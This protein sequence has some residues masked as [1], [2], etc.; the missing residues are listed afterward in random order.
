MIVHL[1]TNFDISDTITPLFI[2]KKEESNFYEKTYIM[3]P[4]CFGI[5]AFLILIIAVFLYM[6]RR[7]ELIQ[8]KGLLKSF[9]VKS[10]IINDVT[11][12]M[13][14]S[15]MQDLLYVK[16]K[17]KAFIFLCTESASNLRRDITAETS[18]MNDLDKRFNFDFDGGNTEPYG[19]RNVNLLISFNSDENLTNNSPTWL[20]NGSSK[21]NS[22][23]GSI[24]RSGNHSNVFLI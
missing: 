18:L 12:L 5:V 6:R 3:I 2:T 21:T 19:K 4:L 10:I 14:A 7:R 20:N 22:D 8:M 17:V 11:H 23:N 13:F 24:S 16:Q 9:K 1:L 15:S